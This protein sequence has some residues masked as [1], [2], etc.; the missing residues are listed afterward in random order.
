MKKHGFET[1]CRECGRLF[2]TIPSRFDIGKGRFCSKNCL[3]KSKPKVFK[4]CETCKKDFRIKPMRIKTARFCSLEC[5]DRLGINNPFF[6]KRHSFV[7]RKKMSATKNDIPLEEWK[8]FSKS[9]LG[10]IRLSKEYKDWRTAVFKRDNYT[11]VWCGQVGGELNAD[12][13]KSFSLYPKYRFDI[14]NGRTLCIK[15]HKKT[16]SYL[17]SFGKNQ[18]VH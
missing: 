14:D 17:N 13:I 18:Y 15:C 5:R 2:H 11:C 10:M 4:K 1:K 16:E 7:S 9:E 6:N 8:N 12:H 3:F